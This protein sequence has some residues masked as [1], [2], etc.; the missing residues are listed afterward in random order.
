MLDT[1]VLASS[2][3]TRGLCTELFESILYEHELL[4]CQPVLSELAR[5]LTE[6]FHLPA[7]VT[8]DYVSLIKSH[9]EM[10][11]DI[12]D[13]KVKIRDPDDI[14]IIGCAVA[15]RADAF[16]TGDKELLKL[17]HIAAVPVLSPR[18]CWQMLA[19]LRP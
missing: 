13:I 2:L 14:P 10:T 6:K 12:A 4:T 15:A 9:A 11:T 3:T 5:I 1:N 18:Q 17:R 16:V 7:T 19:G 8:R